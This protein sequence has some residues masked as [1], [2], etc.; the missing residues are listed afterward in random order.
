MHPNHPILYDPA[1]EASAHLM[2]SP[3]VAKLSFGVESSMN[4]PVMPADAQ[5]RNTEGSEPA[6]HGD[7]GFHARLIKEEREPE[8]LSWATRSCAI[9]HTLIG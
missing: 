6:E 1:K 3:T 8:R 4:N 7:E 5:E 9:V 2:V